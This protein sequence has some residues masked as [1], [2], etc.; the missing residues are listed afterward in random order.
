MVDSDAISEP[1]HERD[2]P[3]LIA[4]GQRYLA[5]SAAATGAFIV[6]ATFT[7]HVAHER[8]ERA[9]MRNNQT[10]YTAMLGADLSR[11]LPAPY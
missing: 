7:L 5:W 11:R 1:V 6:I 10:A 9:V 8:H 4:R 2:D 3:E